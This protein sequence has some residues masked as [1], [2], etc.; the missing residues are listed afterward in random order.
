ML[1]AAS[2]LAAPASVVASASADDG[3]A[4]GAAPPALTGY[5]AWW[6]DDAWKTT[7]LDG[8]ER[9]IFI[10]QRIDA[11]GR[12]LEA[13]GWPEQWQDLRDAA[14]DAGVGIDLSIALVRE[15]DFIAVFGSPEA[16]RRLLR[17][18]ERLLRGP[19]VA[20][21]HID[22]EVY[23]KAST[24]PE[25]IAGFREFIETLSRRAKRSKRWELSAF[26]PIGGER[27]LY[28][29]A[30]LA[31]MSRV[32]VQGYDAHWP[33]GPRAG[34]VA[35]LHGPEAVTWAKALAEARALGVD[36]A[37]ISLAF[38]LYGYEW[39]VKGEGWRRETSGQGR[40]VPFAAL[41]PALRG[42]F[43][44]SV[45]ER[46]AAHGAV[47][48]AGPASGS[49]AFTVAGAR[50]EGWFEDWTSLRIKRQWLACEGVDG[51]ALFALGYDAGA[52]V[53]SFDRS[54]PETSTCPATSRGVS[55]VRGSRH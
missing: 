51:M 20:G 26:L 25:A 55:A 21:L 36:N 47:F 27:Q 32:V 3:V 15:S 49:Y 22:I 43:P 37:R 41:P 9:L 6:L 54:I 18:T 50:W 7:P 39:P 44:S 10:E 48:H 34:P 1:M 16:R 28:A 33:D 35:P 11:T 29:P 45:L 53:S 31:G 38:P 46:V 17:E 40:V 5:V 30:S 14:R 23:R 2:L 4:S 19:D 12:I 8:F 24:S 42:N 52:L 13:N